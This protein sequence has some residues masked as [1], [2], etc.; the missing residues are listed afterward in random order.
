MELRHLRYF[1]AIVE[2]NG[3]QKASLHLHVA[4]PALT[5]TVQD[6]EHEL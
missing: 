4:Q 5:Q 3:Y 2:C 1:V 6:L